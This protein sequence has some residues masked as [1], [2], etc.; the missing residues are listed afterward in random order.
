M[1]YLLDL[2]TP[3]TWQAFQDAGSQVIGFRPRQR[4]LAAERVKQGD[5]LLCYLT[6]L[7]RWCGVLRVD[8]SVYEASNPLFAEPDPF[9][10]RFKVHPI[11]VLEPEVAI[12]IHNQTVWTALSMTRRYDPA[13]SHWTGFFS[14]LIE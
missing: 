12:P 9:T 4:S 14:K 11:V 8:S 10:I 5:I 6:R 13:S 1:N 3:E 7:S 2:F